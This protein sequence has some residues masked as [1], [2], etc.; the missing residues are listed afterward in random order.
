MTSEDKTKMELAK[1]E[2]C[3]KDNQTKVKDKCDSYQ[4]YIDDKESEV[5]EQAKVVASIAE[6]LPEELRFRFSI[7]RRYLILR[8]SQLAA[9]SAPSL[10]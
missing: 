10:F 5:K 1:I 2:T 8:G 4:R 3:V 7:F 6:S 9:A